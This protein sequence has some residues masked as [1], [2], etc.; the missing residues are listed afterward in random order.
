MRI[1]NIEVDFDFFDADNIEKFESEA[2]KVV[3]KT[4]KEKQ[5]ENMT[6]SNA[7]RLEC[8]IVEEF[9]DNVFGEGIS[10][11]IFKGKKNLMEHIKVFQ[12]IVDEK[13]RKQQE[14]QNLYN[15]YAPNNSNNFKRKNRKNV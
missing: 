11:K 14:L 4:E 15:R 7:I 3:E 8:D 1:K 12:E 6:L 10:E 13:N 2:R 9:L 5:T